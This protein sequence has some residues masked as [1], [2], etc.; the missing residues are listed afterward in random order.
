MTNYEK[1]SFIFYFLGVVVASILVLAFSLLVSIKDANASIIDMQRIAQIESSGN[2]L[3][4]NKREDG[5][6]LYQINPICLREWNNFH[7]R[8]QYTPDD[9]FNAEINTRIADWYMN[10]R[11]PQMIRHFGKP[12]TVENRIICWNAG[13]NYVKTGKEIPQ[14]TKNFIAKYN[15]G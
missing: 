10:K 12:D 9:L 14:I 6:G 13:I 7:P 4:H 5:R 15:R 2:P 11:I 8:E 3:A 1:E